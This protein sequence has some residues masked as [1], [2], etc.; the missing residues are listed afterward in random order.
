[1]S[2]FSSFADLILAIEKDVERVIL[3]YICGYVPWTTF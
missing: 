3:P 1:M 2:F